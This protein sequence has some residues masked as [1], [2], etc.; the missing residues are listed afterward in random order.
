MIIDV[1][2]KTGEILAEPCF[3]IVCYNR[4][5]QHKVMILQ[6]RAKMRQVMVASI[7]HELRTPLNSMIILLQLAK[8]YPG[9]SKEFKN[10]Y[11]IPALHQSEYLLC[12]INDILDY[13]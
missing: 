3:I 6:N 2:I 11:T 1:L 10:T 8:D 7:S 5:F 12:L 4:N 9:L 13:T